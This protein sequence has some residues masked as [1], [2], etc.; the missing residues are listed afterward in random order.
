MK[1]HHKLGGWKVNSVG[2]HSDHNRERISSAVSAIN[3]DRANSASAPQ[4]R[5]LSPPIEL[6]YAL[7]VDVTADTIGADTSTGAPLDSIN[8]LDCGPRTPPIVVNLTGM[9][10]RADDS[11]ISHKSL[12]HLH[13]YERS[14]SIS[15]ASTDVDALKKEF[16]DHLSNS[17]VDGQGQD[18]PTY[19]VPGGAAGSVGDS[20]LSSCR[21]T[22]FEVQKGT[23][24]STLVAS[25][26]NITA[27]DNSEPY[28]VHSRIMGWKLT[29]LSRRKKLMSML[30]KIQEIPTDD[31]IELSY[32]HSEAMLA[33]AEK[34]S[35]SSGALKL[36]D[37]AMSG[38]D[39]NPKEI[40]PGGEAG[41]GPGIGMVAGTKSDINDSFYQNDYATS[42]VLNTYSRIWNDPETKTATLR[43]ATS[44]SKSKREV[45][46]W[47]ASVARQLKAF[48]STPTGKAEKIRRLTELARKPARGSTVDGMS[49]GREKQLTQKLVLKKR[50]ESIDKVRRMHAPS[51]L[52]LNLLRERD[53]MVSVVLCNVIYW[54]T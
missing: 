2:R 22:S 30:D 34:S 6:G 3:T 14:S 33:P 52:H 8:G 20:P 45:D 11:S 41:T 40:T 7:K 39:P 48:E 47:E 42:S 54:N 1:T 13:N 46:A 44:R 5:P 24:N 49:A 31:M 27:S 4:L 51:E 12:A 37:S 36:N 15:H 50:D 53:R 19:V 18:L 25:V 21:D 26:T 9:G 29:S 35:S 43:A 28:M 10:F 17:L 23:R 38:T 32:S 16:V